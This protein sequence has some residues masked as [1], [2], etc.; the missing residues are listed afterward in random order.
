MGRKEETRS[1]QSVC[2]FVLFCFVLPLLLQEEG[3][4]LA[5]L[6]FE[7]FRKK[8]QLFEINIEGWQATNNQT[9]ERN[10]SQACARRHPRR[11][12]S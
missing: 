1:R 5:F 7:F 2:L 8:E 4:N 10:G 9:I 11:W 6:K 12:V 3:T